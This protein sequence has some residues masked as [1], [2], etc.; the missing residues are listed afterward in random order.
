MIAVACAMFKG[1]ELFWFTVSWPEA[2]LYV[3]GKTASPVAGVPLK[4]MMKLDARTKSIGFAGTGI[5]RQLS[6]QL[7]AFVQTWIL[8]GLRQLGIPGQPEMITQA[9][10]EV[11]AIA[12]T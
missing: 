8:P 4:V 2:E 6:N 3:Y 7:G 12:G 9:A 10:H 11:T 1:C 5:A